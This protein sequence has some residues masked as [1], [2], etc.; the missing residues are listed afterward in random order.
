M[1]KNPKFGKCEN[2]PFHFVASHGL[3]DVADFMIE[4]LQSGEDCLCCFRHHHGYC[5]SRYYHGYCHYSLITNNRGTTPLHHMVEDRGQAKIIRSLRR[6]LDFELID[7]YLYNRIILAA[8]RYENLDCIKALIE[9]QTPS[10]QKNVVDTVK[11]YYFS[12]NDF[13]MN[14]NYYKIVLYL[15]KDFIGGALYLI[16]PLIVIVLTATFI[17]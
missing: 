14:L 5:Y 17:L 7:P 1:N 2:T 12:K 16:F 8:L 9:K 13:W 10:F 3:S 15:K 6:K 4:E 11:N